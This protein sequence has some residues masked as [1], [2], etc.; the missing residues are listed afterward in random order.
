MFVLAA[1]VLGALTALAVLVGQAAS[2]SATLA[3]PFLSRQPCVVV[4]A[5]IPAA[6]AALAAS[7]ASYGRARG[8]AGA[9]ENRPG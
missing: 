5:A 8:G 9:G 6:A 7:G 1:V 3:L 4:L 2:G